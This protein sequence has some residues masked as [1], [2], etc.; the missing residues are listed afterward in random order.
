[1][2]TRISLPGELALHAIVVDPRVAIK[3]LAHVGDDPANF[4]RTIGF[5]DPIFA[6]AR[7]RGSHVALRWV[8]NPA[9]GIPLEPFTV[10]RRP[11]RFR[12]RAEP[13]ANLHPV[14]GDTFWWDGLTE[15]MLVEVDVDA[16]VTLFGLSSKDHEA[17]VVASGG[18]GTIVLAGG[19][20]LGV[21]ASR[22]GAI[23]RA[24]GLAL[25]R[26]A[27]GDGWKPI[28]RVGLPLENALLAASYYKAEQQ[29][30]FPAFTDPV[31]AAI[32]RI[33]RWAP[34]VG[35]STLAGL[36]PWRAPDAKRLVAEFNAELLPDL[37]AVLAAHPAPNVEGQV[38]AE[39]PP[40][41]LSEFQQFVGLKPYKFGAG[42]NIV[43]SEI[44]T[45]PLQAVM[46]GAASDTWASL[47]LGFG[48]GA[49]IGV[50]DQGLGLD[51]FMVTAPWQGHLRVAVPSRA[52]WP[53][54]APPVEMVAKEV[55]REL[56]AIALSPVPRAAPPAPTPLIAAATYV[57]GAPEP[58]APFSSATKIETIRSRFAPGRTRAS[59]YSLARFDK[60]S[61]GSYRLRERSASGGWI[62]IGAAQ[63]VVAPGTKPDPTL[64]AGAVMLR[65]NGVARPIAGAAHTYQYAVAATDLFGQ[66]S[67]WSTAWLELGPGDVQTPAVTI[68]RASAVVGVGG[69]DP[70]ALTAVTEIVWDAS[71]RTCARVRVVIDLFDPTPDPPAALAAPPNSPHLGFAI[72]DVIVAF[73]PNGMPVAPPAGVTV[74][75]LHADDSEV[76]AARPFEDDDRRYRIA[77][78]G[79][80]VTYGAAPEKAIAIYAL[81]EERIRPGKWSPAW[82]HARETIIAPNPIPPAT[83]QPLPAVYPQWASLPN[84]A[85][86][87]L[88]PLAWSPSGAWRYRVFEATETAL[89]VACGHAGPVLTDGF[90]TRM[91]VLFDLYKD[92]NN[93]AKLRAAYRK[94]GTEPILPALQPDG[95]MR[96][97]A[98]L[99]RGSRSIHCFII[100]GVAETNVISDWPVPDVDGRRGFFAFAIPRPLQPPIPEISA[101]VGVSG[102]PEI[103]V[104]VGGAM[105][106]TSIRLY[107]AT[108]SVLA[109]NVGTMERISTTVPNPASP[110]TTD[111]VDAT[112]VPGWD[113]VHYRAVARAD[114]DLDRAGIAIDSPASKTY[115][116]LFAPPG[117]P[118]FTLADV[119]ASRTVTRAVIA[120]ATDAPHAAKRVGDHLVSW[121]VRAP[122]APP[123]RGSRTLAGLPLFADLPAFLAS[124]ETA[125]Y[126]TGAIYLKLSRTLGAP[127]ALSVDLTD[128]L[129]RAT[130]RLFDVP[131]FVADPAP[132]IANFRIE[133]RGNFADHAAW[134]FFDSNAPTSPDPSREWQLVLNFRR[135]GFIGPHETQTFALSAIPTAASEGD[136][137]TP[138]DVML[139]VV[140]R[141]IDGT[142]RFIVWIR[143]FR[144]QVSVTLQNSTGET[145]IERGS[146]L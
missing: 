142:G 138:A 100:V 25:N 122:D 136:V 61:S 123:E 74:T 62:P 120:I 13:I 43:N 91:Q 140:V 9:L 102:R 85:G 117:P 65:D 72:A 60:A 2:A 76:T 33:M 77:I 63:P 129:G 135:R 113:Y 125:G 87:S 109:R 1:M 15:M 137:P 139:G 19:A 124:T 116:L 133:A 21:R 112:A 69:G 7:K 11:V 56:A 30:P 101:R 18:P 41:P 99:P 64:T 146:S 79:L 126:A 3:N 20:M 92:R 82:G 83:P 24:R 49:E 97:D 66:W 50:N 52:V 35:W 111:I 134:I 80:P 48:T 118:I 90:E 103:R 23:Q 31:S 145:A 4:A 34:V 58:D 130:H 39:R 45:R 86:E 26:M 81:A 38:A 59:G 28:E 106:A 46:I 143:S 44:V 95:R 96:F 42:A 114:D 73:D 55:R 84:A 22:P 36:A 12:E 104:V 47:C 110:A 6:E 71:E 115:D 57:E 127:L 5:D 68:S 105:P 98:K 88:A 89:L 14:G 16:A 17:I 144:L 128:P 78:A 121:I 93:L 67:P 141:R 107:R 94:L 131:A 37:V 32:D 75:P 29:G 51:D 70:C 8:I 108:K 10:W 53:R 40:R 27:N 132:T 119:A 54:G